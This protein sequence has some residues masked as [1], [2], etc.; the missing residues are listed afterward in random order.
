M[1]LTAT[2]VIIQRLDGRHNGDCELALTTR[3]VT[4]TVRL[5]KMG[6]A[7]YQV[8]TVIERRYVSIACRTRRVWLTSAVHPARVRHARRRG[9]PSP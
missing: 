3:L 9:S 2:G 8:P 7:V 5:G 4:C 1:G 6:W